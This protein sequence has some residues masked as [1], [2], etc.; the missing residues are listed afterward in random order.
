VRSITTNAQ[1]RFSVGA[2]V[3]EHGATHFRVWAPRSKSVTIVERFPRSS[4]CGRTQQLSPEPNGFY[5]GR[6]TELPCGALYSVR[7]DSGLYPDP[8]SRFQPE[9]PHG[10]SQV[11]DATRFAWHDAGFREATDAR[12]IYELH[13]GTFTPEGTYHA[14][15]AQMA[16]LADLGITVVELMSLGGFAGRWGWSYDT[17]NVWAPSQVYGTPDDLRALVATAHAHGIAVIL[18]VIY[19][20]IGADGNYLHAFCEDY[21][22]RTHASE[23]GETFN[24]DGPSSGP[25]RQFV[26]ENARYWIEEF[27]FDGLRLDATQSVFDDTRPHVLAEIT[28]A[29]RAAGASLGKP[30]FIVGENEPQ[31]PIL[32]RST[33]DGGYGLDAVW[34]DDFHHSARVA[35]TGRNEG[36]FTDYLGKPQELISALRWGYLYQGQRYQWQQQARGRAALDFEARQF[37]VYLQNHDQIANQI[38][39]ERL[40][41]LTSAAELRA[42]T[43]LMLLSPPT[44]MLFQGQEF[45]ASS[46]FLYFTDQDPNLLPNVDRDRRKFLAQFPSLATDEAQ[47]AQVS[48]SARSTFERCKLDF[49]ER[50]LHAPIYQLHRDLLRLRRQDPAIRQRRADRMH[51]AV[52]GERALCIRFFCPDGDRL[53]ITNLGADLHLSPA[54]EPLLAPPDASG[55]NMLWCSESYAYGGHGVPS[56]REDGVLVVPARCSMLYG[57]NPQ[58]PS[59]PRS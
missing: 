40:D 57:P 49:N 26:T 3:T 45:A 58:R 17:V 9:G 35:L 38:P 56:P 16:E 46:P 48:V 24:F 22:S 43:A 47:A 32:L 4:E 34:N 39:G 41:R 15:A 29:A 42:M 27:H 54:P 50:E 28:T 13:V 59:E 18:D 10:P 5:S 23:W 53:L 36:Y 12:V 2:E 25:V 8:A 7:L 44:P 51:G 30:I 33:A 11:V 37:V 6:F 31:D 55:W 20:H 14:A 19:N 21:F 52:L 1:R